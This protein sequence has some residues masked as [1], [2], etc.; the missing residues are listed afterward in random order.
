[1]LVVRKQENVTEWK[2]NSCL[3]RQSEKRRQNIGRMTIDEAPYSVSELWNVNTNWP[4]NKWYSNSNHVRPEVR[5]PGT[6]GTVTK[7]MEHCFQ[8]HNQF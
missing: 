6:L 8:K 7:G 3:L 1:M 4:L 2:S 5:S